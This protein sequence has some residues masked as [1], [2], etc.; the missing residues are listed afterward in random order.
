[1]ETIFTVIV[2]IFLY[3]NVYTF[4]VSRQNTLED[5]AT[6]VQQIDFERSIE[7]L[8][9]IRPLFTIGS[10]QVALRCTINNTGPLAVQLV[11]LWVIDE[12]TSEHANAIL[13]IALSPGDVTQ[14]SRVVSIPSASKSHQYSFWLV[15]ARGNAVT[16]AVPEKNVLMSAVSSGIGS[17]LL[18]FNNFRYFNV[19]RQGKKYFLANL[20]GSSG[21]Q[22]NE[23]SHAWDGVA[24]GVRLTNL[25]SKNRSITLDASS[26]LFSLFPE[27]VTQVR[28][29]AWYLVNVNLT[30]GEIYSTVPS[31]QMPYGQ[32]VTLFF[33]SQNMI[34]GNNFS[35][36][37]S[38]FTGT[39][40][41]NLALIGTIGTAGNS[42][43]FGQNIPFVSIVINSKG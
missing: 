28:G 43:P 31:I 3:F 8:N 29:A 7:Q 34:T 6:Q 19:T 39:A 40:P 5:T 41:V 10:G 23:D 4:M 42:Q 22:V 2:I 37:F 32:P 17:I 38:S 21:Y 11:R 30:D 16:I 33:A 13:S 15:T 9:I 14:F 35:P 18:D 25:D 1:M 26:V 27:S 36:A 20:Q 24:F 12:N